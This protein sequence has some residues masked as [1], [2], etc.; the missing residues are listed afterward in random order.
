VQILKKLFQVIV[1]KANKSTFQS[2]SM[3]YVTYHP[4]VRYNIYPKI[5]LTDDLISYTCNRVT[6]SALIHQDSVQNL[7]CM[8]MLLSLTVHI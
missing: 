1:S 5:V 2:E 7:Q 8:I 6:V 4:L 3:F